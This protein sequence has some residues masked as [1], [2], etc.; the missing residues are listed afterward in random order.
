ML[1][2]PL[3]QS[4]SARFRSWRASRPFWGG[5]LLVVS[6]LCL[7]LPAFATIRVGDLLISI[8][9]ISGVSTL[10]LGSLMLV[11]AG[12]VLLQPGARVP[13]GVVAM[14]LALVALPAANFGGF[15]IGT[16]LG[17]VGSAAALSWRRIEDAP[18]AM[19]STNTEG[20]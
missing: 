20:A 12:T 15:F 2:N 4:R 18:T 6:G 9:T 13:A 16:L 10:L 11:C 8:S 19:P 7:L 14:L 1:N 17:V 5:A 3:P